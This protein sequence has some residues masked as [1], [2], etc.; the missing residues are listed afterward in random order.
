MDRRALVSL[1]SLVC[2]LAACSR[3]AVPDEVLDGS[4]LVS[5]RVMPDQTVVGDAD[6][7]AVGLIEIVAQ[8][9]PSGPAPTV[10]VALV[11]DTS[12]S[13]DG[14][15]I[16]N[17]RSAA[18]ALV[19]ALAPGDRLTLVSYGDAATTHASCVRLRADRTELHDAIDDLE[20][21]GNTCASCGL[22]A[23]YD[24]LRTCTDATVERAV[25]LSD[26][27]ANRGI[28][29]AG[30]LA[31]MVA[32]ARAS[33]GIETSTIGL[34]RLHDEHTLGALASAGAA[35]YH[36]LASSAQ[37][38]ALL[39]AELDD[40][41]AT[42]VTNVRVA[43]RAGDGGALIGTPMLG[44]SGTSEEYVFDL[45]QLAIGESRELLVQLA[46]PPGD[47]GRAL[48]ARVFFDDAAG[49]AY[50]TRGHTNIERSLNAGEVEASIDARVVEAFL[51]LQ[52]AAAIDAALQTA[53]DTPTKL[54][55]LTTQRNE[56]ERYRDELGLP[57]EDIN[58]SPVELDVVD[59][60]AEGQAAA[61]PAP[62]RAE[63]LRTNAIRWDRRSGRPAQRESYAAGAIDP[64]DLD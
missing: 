13:M 4:G 6:S 5:V 20:A 51:A 58:W 40:L 52:T 1:V 32:A 47:P 16:E 41:R 22:Q 23:A 35:D 44:A 37:L 19:D 18:H 33:A 39:E 30:P 2:G 24:A 7:D 57:A 46:L 43:I 12:G 34:G 10:H 15:R 48:T 17:A 9:A 3:S 45:G 8:R 25:L 11:L 38:D 59:Q 62:A 28:T 64:A 55:N 29:D 61:A 60:L 53:I 54:Q 63:A 49:R 27:H 31:S 26:G 21:E 36:F 42:S 50:V 14:H 56:L